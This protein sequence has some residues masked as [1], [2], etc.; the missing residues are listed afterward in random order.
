[1]KTIELIFYQENGSDFLKRITGRIFGLLEDKIIEGMSG[2][3]SATRAL[4]R[5]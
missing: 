2:V 5:E 1:M 3:V 4:M